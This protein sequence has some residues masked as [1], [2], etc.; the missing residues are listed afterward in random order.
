MEAFGIPVCRGWRPGLRNPRPP[1][2]L[3]AE[4]AVPPPR[5]DLETMVRSLTLALALAACG[6]ESV[7]PNRELQVRSITISVADLPSAPVFL[8]G[9]SYQLV[10]TAY[11]SAARP[12][13]GIA[14]AWATSDSTAVQISSSGVLHLVK[15]GLYYI[16]ASYRNITRLVS[17]LVEVPAATIELSMDSSHLV[18]FGSTQLSAI[19]RDSNRAILP[20]RPLTWTSSDPGIGTVSATGRVSAAKV[21]SFVVR[22]SREGLGDSTIV[23]VTAPRYSQVATG[24]TVACAAATT[25]DAYCWGDNSEGQLGRG[26]TFPRARGATD[27]V[28]AIVLGGHRFRRVFAGFA[29]A[30]GIALDDTAWCWGRNAEGQLGDGTTLTRDTPVLVAGGFSFDTLALGQISTCGITTSGQA[31]CWGSNPAGQTGTI[32][33]SNLTPAPV[34]GGVQFRALATTQ[35]MIRYGQWHSCGLDQSGAAWCWGRNFFGQLGDST[36][37]ILGD[38]R[39]APWGHGTPAR[40]AGGLVFVSIAV[41]AE[42]SCGILSTGKRACWGSNG[43]LALGNDTS[44]VALAPALLNDSLSWVNV[45]AGDSHGCGLVTGGA[46]YCWGSNGNGALGQPR[47]VL[48]SALPR[49]LGGYQFVQFSTSGTRS[50]GITTSG[51]AICWGDGRYT[52]VFVPGQ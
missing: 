26:T 39:N 18:P 6:V 12:V 25:G 50:C 8:P 32:A 27:P 19:L 51:Y 15:P 33:A 24:V 13:P 34:Q 41:G 22:V 42:F 4:V 28:P 3:T 45:Q 35:R 49:E 44:E 48:S 38:P 2:R 31:L 52:Q 30:C 37:A 10:A 1:D 40:V 5:C 11:D 23:Q 21:G 43:E 7:T 46:V 14:V 9:D 29:H 20:T 17:V 47:P 16:T 36:Q